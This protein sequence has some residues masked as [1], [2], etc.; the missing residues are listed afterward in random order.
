MSDRIVY[1]DGRGDVRVT[2]G[3]IEPTRYRDRLKITPASGQKAKYIDA[4]Q[5]IS[6]EVPDLRTPN[7][8]LAAVLMRAAHYAASG[9]IPA[10]EA[11]LEEA[12][13]MLAT[14]LGRSQVA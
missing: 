8:Q 10:T 14:R 3:T 11:D 12:M 2:A 1:K 6:A 5:L 7:P 4:S 13:A 9:D